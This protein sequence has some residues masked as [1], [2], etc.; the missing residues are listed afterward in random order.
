MK[1]NLWFSLITQNFLITFLAAQGDK[2]SLP[3]QINMKKLRHFKYDIPLKS[4]A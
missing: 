4:F 2:A 1:K 3:V